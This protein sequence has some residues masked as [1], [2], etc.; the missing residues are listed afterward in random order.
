MKI[1]SLQ[2]YGMRCLLK[3]AE[4]GTSQ[5]VQI[6]S[7]AEKEGLSTDYVG[8]ILT[9]LRKSG[10]VRS[11]RGLKGGYVL[12]R[13]AEKISIGEAIMALSENP[14]ELSHL[15]RDLCRQFPGN[16]KE[17]VH[18]RSC[19]VRQIWSMVI[20]QVFSNLNRIPISKLLGTENEV[21]EALMDHVKKAAASPIQW[22][23]GKG[24][25]NEIKEEVKA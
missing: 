6:R 3:L 7:I 25:L 16:R 21:Q 18:L 4:G 24:Q 19:S 5:P 15:K 22:V 9:R 2:E 11:V 8:K 20:V 17:C 14:V 1:T 12:T 13:E 10:L 23:N